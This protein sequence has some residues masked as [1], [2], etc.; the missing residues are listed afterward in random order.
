MSVFI[1][2]KRS[3]LEYL[4][5]SNGTTMFTLENLVFSDPAPIA[6]TWRE[7][8]TDKNTFMKVNA[9][10]AAGFKGRTV[11][12]YNR[13]ELGDFDHFKPAA[14]RVLQVYQPSTVHDILSNILYYWG[15]FLTE[16][17]IENDPIT[18]DENGS[19]SVVLRAKPTSPIWM[20]ELG[21]DLVI[22]GANIQDLLAVT[23]LNGL[24]YPVD[25]PAT[26]TSALLYV[27]P[28]D[29][30]EWRDELLMIEDD[31]HVL[32]EAEAQSLVDKLKAVDLGA[33]AAL[34]NSDSESTEWSLD[35][36]SVFHNGLNSLA[37]PTNQ[38]YKYVIGID[39]K[40]GNTIPSGRMYLHYNDPDDPNSAD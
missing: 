22:G 12:T 8:T 15:L 36:A 10:E 11:I 33:G 6:G 1:N 19:G 18:L 34:W 30:T 2:S 35:G 29:M 25:D 17:D 38:A 31:G 37:Y 16:D 20:G 14:K 24:N 27:Y 28:F 3:L 40:E 4:N 23:D 13:L 26:Q 39:F 32:T 21:I 9:A 5:N 7:E